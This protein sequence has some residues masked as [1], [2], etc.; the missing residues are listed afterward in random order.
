MC[1]STNTNIDIN[2]KMEVSV[3]VH[4][5]MGGCKHAFVSATHTHCFSIWKTEKL[6]VLCSLASNHFSWGNPEAEIQSLTIQ[7]TLKNK[8][9]RSGV[10]RNVRNVPIALAEF[11]LSLTRPACTK[12][13]AFIILSFSAF[14]ILSTLVIYHAN[15]GSSLWLL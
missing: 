6:L 9:L 15:S 14:H 3:G 10:Q 1:A 7:A 4:I 11:K 5:W 12:P 13:P 2:T 8:G